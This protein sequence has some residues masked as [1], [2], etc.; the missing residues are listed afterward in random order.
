M[1]CRCE[2][3]HKVDVP[4]CIGGVGCVVGYSWVMA[5]AYENQPFIE[6]LVPWVIITVIFLVCGILI[7]LCIF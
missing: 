4:I 1:C 2:P 7:S 5:H 6:A 3:N